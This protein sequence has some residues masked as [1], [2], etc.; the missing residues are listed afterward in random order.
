MSR[1]PLQT[2][3][4]IGQGGGGNKGVLPPPPT[5]SLGEA[6]PTPFLPN[7]SRGVK[8]PSNSHHGRIRGINISA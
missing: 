5:P 3:G 8:W 1:D 4:V 2:E 6:G 7:A